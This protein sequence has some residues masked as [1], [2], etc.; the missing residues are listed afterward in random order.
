M[1]K[2]E[3]LAEIEK[4]NSRI[5]RLEECI[6]TQDRLIE[7]YQKREQSVL[8]AMETVE[9]AMERKLRDAEEKASEIE[10]GAK[11]ESDRLVTEARSMAETYQQTLKQYNDALGKAA[12]QAA[13][14]MEQLMKIAKSLCL[15]END[16]AKLIGETPAEMQEKTADG[17]AA[18]SPAA[19]MQGIYRLENRTAPSNDDDE[20]DGKLVKV[21]DLLNE[22]EEETAAPLNEL[23]EEIMKAGEE[24]YGEE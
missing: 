23:L 17:N 19:V 4:L 1:R 3:L 24:N 9:N 15:P 18:D 13:A 22:K 14:S 12:D 20:E 2:K 21:S 5:L 10:S 16:T 11:D 7:T 6:R 8:Q